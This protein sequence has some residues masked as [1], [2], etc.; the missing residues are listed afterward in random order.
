MPTIEPDFRSSIASMAFA[1]TRGSSSLKADWKIGRSLSEAI[2]P[3]AILI[4]A[5]IRGF[6]SWFKSFLRSPIARELFILPTAMIAPI[7]ASSSKKI[8]EACSSILFCSVDTFPELFS[9]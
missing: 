4:E 6:F 9:A 7:I 3:K 2:I 1:L 5:L 8:C